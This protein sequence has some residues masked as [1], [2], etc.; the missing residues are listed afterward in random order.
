MRSARETSSAQPTGAER[1]RPQPNGS[2][3]FEPLVELQ[4]GLGNQALLRLLAGGAAQRKPKVA[5]PA[6]DFEQQAD[7]IAAHITSN[8]SG[9][10]VQRKCAACAVGAPCSECA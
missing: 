6:D 1:A 3:E 5:I 9:L 4:Q 2:A 7:L 8:P 10:M